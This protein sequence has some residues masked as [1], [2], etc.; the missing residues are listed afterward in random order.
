MTS[1]NAALSGSPGIALGDVIGSNV[2]NVLLVFAI[3]VMIR[4]IPVNP[5]AITR[6]GLIMIAASLVLIALALYFHELTRLAGG[7]LLTLL[8]LY[9][10]IVWRLERSGGP[11]AQMHKGEAHTHDP[12]PDALWLSGLFALGGLGLLVFGADLLVEGATTLARIVGMSE[13]AIGITVVA[14]GTS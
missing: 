1:V 14:V 5:A 2:S 9:I 7:A 10:L 3:I 13:T 6:D 8:V 4:P 11:A 12:A